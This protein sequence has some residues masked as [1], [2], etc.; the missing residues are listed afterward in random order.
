MTEGSPAMMLPM[1][2][3]ERRTGAMKKVYLSGSILNWLPM[4]TGSATT[5]FRRSATL[6]TP[7]SAKPLTTTFS[8]SRAQREEPKTSQAMSTTRWRLKYCSSASAEKV[9]ASTTFAAFKTVQY[10]S[11]EPCRMIGGRKP[12]GARCQRSFVI[13]P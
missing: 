11:L 2:R 9:K 13:S 1:P 12:L 10:A 4:S 6:D 7:C 5:A 8:F 3:T